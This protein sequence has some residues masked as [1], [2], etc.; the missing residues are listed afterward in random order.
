MSM[1]YLSDGRKVVVIG[2]L[3]N[4]ETIV[5]EIFITQDGGEIPSGEQFTVKSLHDQ[6]VL[7]YREKEAQ[8]AEESISRLDQEIKTRMLKKARMTEDLKGLAAVLKSSQKLV[9]RLPTTTLETFAAF[10]TGTIEYLVVDHYSITP[11][12]KM[13]DEV[14]RKENRY[15]GEDKTFDSIKLISVLGRSD[16]NLEYNIHDYSD[17]SGGTTQVYPFT[18]L[19][20]ALAHIKTRAE[21]KID[22]D[23]LWA[24]DY[25]TC[26]KMGILF[27]TEHEHKYQK[28]ASEQRAKAV[29]VAKAELEKCQTK[30][31]GLLAN[32]LC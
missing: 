18:T 2:K 22:G 5:Q 1:K 19:K 23:R 16:G 10:L 7:S 28:F 13:L 29:N 26:I 17:G 12:V 9:E 11:P 21:I 3:N 25:A 31:N 14:V 30:L 6:P 15:C 27:S 8:K 4:T 20:E 24:D 32:K